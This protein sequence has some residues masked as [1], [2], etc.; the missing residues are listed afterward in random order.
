VDGPIV[1]ARLM[2][3]PSSAWRPFSLPTAAV[4]TAVPGKA[5]RKPALSASLISTILVEPSRLTVVPP[6]RP[7]WGQANRA[8]TAAPAVAGLGEWS[9]IV[10][11]LQ[12]GGPRPPAVGPAPAPIRC[13]SGC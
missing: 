6:D 10:S 8:G 4:R 13:S 2:P 7:G 3:P 11:I 9:W 1:A 5:R 12:P